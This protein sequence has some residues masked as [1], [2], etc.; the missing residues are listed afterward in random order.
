[1]KLL[2][3]LQPKCNSDNSRFAKLIIIKLVDFYKDEASSRT[4]YFQ[5]HITT[6]A[7]FRAS[8]TATSVDLF[9]QCREYKDQ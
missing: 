3:V 2:F 4:A 9:D 6:N 8:K 7:A 1:M 5:K